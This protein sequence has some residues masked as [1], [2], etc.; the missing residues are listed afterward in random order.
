VTRAVSTVVGVALLVGITMVTLAALT[1]S[2][3]TVVESQADRADANRA[4]DA[5][6]GLVSAEGTTAERLAFSEGRFHTADRDLR[7]L[8][9]GS[10]LVRERI[11]ALVYDSGEQRVAALGGAVIRQNGASAWF[12]REPRVTAAESGGTTAVVVGAVRIEGSVAVSGTVDTR[13]RG[14]ASHTRRSLGGGKIGVAV[15]TEPADPWIEYFRDHGA[16]VSRVDLDGD[17][18]ASVVGTFAAD[19]AHLL[20]HRVEVTLDD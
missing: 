8:Q 11:G 7:I 1:A 13:L 20:V 17:G 12:A 14:S 10:V 2:V 4:A 19:E 6:E 16:T 15:E 18:R 5:L 3:G 9:N